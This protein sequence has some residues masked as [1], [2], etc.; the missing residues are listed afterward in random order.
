MGEAIKLFPF[1]AV[2]AM[3]GLFGH[4]I[5]D[6]LTMW[7]GAGMAVVLVV[8]AAIFVRVSGAPHV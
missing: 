4:A 1:I 8:F 5:H 6:S 7:V 3:L 2:F